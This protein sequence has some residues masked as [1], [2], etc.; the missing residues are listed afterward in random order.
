MGGEDK[1]GGSSCDVDEGDDDYD[2]G[3]NGGEFTDGEGD[4]SCCGS[5]CI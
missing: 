5:R 3:G 1:D 4:G 2:G